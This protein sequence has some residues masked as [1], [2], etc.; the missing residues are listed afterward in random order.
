MVFKH[1]GTIFNEVTKDMQESTDAC[2]TVSSKVIQSLEIIRIKKL[3][4]NAVLRN[5]YFQLMIFRLYTVYNKHEMIK[6]G[7][8][9]REK[10]QILNN[11]VA[12]CRML[13]LDRFDKNFHILLLYSLQLSST[14]LLKRNFNEI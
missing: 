10:Y 5:K 4:S 12:D 1:L 6:I 7:N 2:S 13:C 3:T 8:Q 9:T 11:F 14:N